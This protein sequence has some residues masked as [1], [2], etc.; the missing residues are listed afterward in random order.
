MEIIKKRITT[1]YKGLRWLHEKYLE[2]VREGK[3]TLVLIVDGKEMTITPQLLADEPPVR[4][5]EKYTEQF[6]VERG[7]KYRLYGF[8]F[9]PDQMELF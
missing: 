4:G 5:K 2:P 7:K 9:I 1:E 6:G 8:K 3:A